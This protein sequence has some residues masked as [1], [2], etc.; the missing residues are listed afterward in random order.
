MQL[1]LKNGKTET[2]MTCLHLSSTTMNYDKL[3]IQTWTTIYAMEN[4]TNHPSFLKFSENISEKVSW[5][6]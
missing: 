1:P 3:E 5:L 6:G 4:E 2:Q